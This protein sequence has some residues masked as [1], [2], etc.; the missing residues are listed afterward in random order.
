MEESTIC[1]TSLGSIAVGQTEGVP[2]KKE[3]M[4]TEYAQWSQNVGRLSGVEIE[5]Q[6]EWENG[7]E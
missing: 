4:G 1:R 3:P 7:T 6:V 5:N 2:L